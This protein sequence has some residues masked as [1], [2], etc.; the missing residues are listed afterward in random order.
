MRVM[1]IDPQT[2]DAPRRLVIH[3]RVQGVGFRESM[4]LEAARLGAR[5]WVRNLR[6]G[7]V[8]AVIDGTPD[9]RAA[10]VAWAHRG[11]MTARVTHVDERAADPHERASI[12]ARFVRLPTA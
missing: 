12:G 2:T 10:L 6:D 8:E 7:T 5:G 11:P 1:A 3:G 4:V 9:V